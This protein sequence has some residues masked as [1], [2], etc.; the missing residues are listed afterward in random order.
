MAISKIQRLVVLASIV[1]LGVGQF[2]VN[3][4]WAGEKQIQGLFSLAKMI[5]Q[6]PMEKA[7]SLRERYV[8]V[9]ID[10]IIT[11]PPSLVRSAGVAERLTLNLFEDA[12]FTAELVKVESNSPGSVSWIGTLENIELSQV[13]LVVNKGQ[14]VGNIVFP[15][16]YFQIRHLD[17]GTHGIYE[18]DQAGPAP[19]KDP[20]AVLPKYNMG[21][22]RG[23]LRDDGS[24]IDILVV[25]SGEAR[26]AVGGTTAMNNLIDLAVSETN[27]GYANSNI[28]QRV[29]VVHKAEVYY[30]ESGFNWNQTL[31]RL[32]N[33]SDGYMDNVHQLRDAYCADLVVMI[34]ADDYYCGLAYMMAF[35][36][37]SFESSAF[38]LVSH[39]CATGY[40]SFAHEMGHN[41]GAR[42]DWYVDTQ[43]TP[44][45]YAH[46]YVYPSDR[47]R[48]IMAYNSECSDSGFNC[49]RLPYWS[50]PAVQYGG[51]PMGVPSFYSGAAD[52]ES[53][54]DNTRMTVSNFRTS[55]STGPNP[56][57]KARGSDG[58]ITISK[59][60]LLT[61]TVAL[62]PGSMSGV[63]AD[64]W[65]IAD[66]PMG[67]Y[68]Y[69][70][71]SGWT[72]GLH[73]AA[74]VP[75][76]ALPDTE[77]LRRTLPAGDYTFYFAV[78]DDADGVMDRTWE[79]SVTVTIE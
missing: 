67:Q 36:S 11:T 51:V 30:N 9:K 37:A 77:V 55:C 78:D 49:T 62:S 68:S 75:L 79:D 54:L 20:I 28:I 1:L 5:D 31:T 6:L 32:R 12:V 4:V 39:D 59:D 27:L 48:T 41:M 26:T 24:I 15:G 73:R 46:G 44:F 60:T 43:T 52:N 45:N 57:I 18:M 33:P 3:P 14:L 34:V 47:W 63:D 69:V 17:N 64:W 38:S 16:G 65:I 70:H 29:N 72:L 42:H 53:T 40:F 2:I 10:Q 56:D 71:P 74:M 19:E 25:Y 21:G 76:F 50:N 61:V 7:T 66:S 35:V 22:E 23:T 8:K 13:V 58:P